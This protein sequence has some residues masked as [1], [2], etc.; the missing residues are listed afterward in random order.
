[1]PLAGQR[2]EELRLHG[3]LPANAA[4]DRRVGR[5]RAVPAVGRCH[6]IGSYKVDLVAGVPGQQRSA[7]LGHL[8][9]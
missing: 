4:R 6:S 5:R 7:D 1:M 2:L 9:N 8:Q 3:L